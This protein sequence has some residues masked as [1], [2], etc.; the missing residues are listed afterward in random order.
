MVRK[1]TEGDED[2]K[3]A[4]AREARRAGER[5][6]ARNV[7][8]GASKQRTHLS[9]RGQTTHEEKLAATHR[10]KPEWRAGDEADAEVRTPGAAQTPGVTGT[11]SRGY[12]RE[13]EQVFRAL[14]EEEEAHGGSP[15]RLDDVSR[16]A[17][18]PRE[19]TR[20]VL[21]D[22]VTVHHVA[23][24]IQGAGDPDMGSAFETKPRR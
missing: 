14:A 13:H 2:Q 7:T 1:R 9:D 17:H 4:A 16:A 12:T 3:R 5:P 15:V 6:S 24:E 11:G 19:E 23:T 21:H 22:L 8:T 20:E 18:L 10:G